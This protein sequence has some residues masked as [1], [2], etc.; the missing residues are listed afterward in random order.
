M[1]IRMLIA[2][3]A[4]LILVAGS[5]ATAQ[6]TQG[7]KGTQTASGQVL[8]IREAVQTQNN[9]DGEKITEI[10]VRTRQR[11]ELRMLLGTASMKGDPDFLLVG[12]KVRVR[13]MYEGE[14]DDVVLVESIKNLRTGK[15][16]QIRNADGTLVTESDQIRQQDRDGSCDGDGSKNQNQNRGGRTTTSSGRK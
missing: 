1:K 8:E 5:V 2:A 14:K 6:D 15:T 9:I 10:K 13:Y 12:D 11:M 16:T 4:L 3:A 7:K